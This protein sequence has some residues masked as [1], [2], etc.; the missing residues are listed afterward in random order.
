[1]NKV[2]VDIETMSTHNTNA[3]ILS[4]GVCKF[5]IEDLPHI[6][7]RSGVAVEDVEAAVVLGPR[8][9][10]ERIWIL[11]IKEQLLAGRRVDRGTQD[12]WSK[13]STSAARHWVNPSDGEVTLAMFA[14]EFAAYVQGAEEVWANGMLFD[15]GNI[16]SLYPN[17][18]PWHYRAARD[19]RTLYRNAEPREERGELFVD[20]EAAHDPQVDCRRQVHELWRRHF[21]RTAV[22]EMT[23]R[24]MPRSA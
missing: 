3:L 10:E 6:S 5:E 17:D 16:G 14:Q 20:P 9:E 24:L 15:L 19:A 4:V 13:Q 21:S 11:D 8:F 18:P 22:D 23:Q 7:T 12:F 1:M 2:M